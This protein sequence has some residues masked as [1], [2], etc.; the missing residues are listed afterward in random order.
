MRINSKKNNGSEFIL[1]EIDI[2]LNKYNLLK[3]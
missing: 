1:L 2:Y 3:L